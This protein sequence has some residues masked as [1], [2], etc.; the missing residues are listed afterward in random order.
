MHRCATPCVDQLEGDITSEKAKIKEA[1]DA[2]AD[3]RSELEE[4]RAQV[5]ASEVRATCFFIRIFAEYLLPLL[6]SLT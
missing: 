4:L 1:E 5:T 2:I 3:M 6:L